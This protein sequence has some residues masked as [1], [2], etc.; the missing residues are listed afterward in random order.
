MH[1]TISAA[2]ARKKLSDLLGAAHHGQARIVITRGGKPYAAIVSLEA[3]EALEAYE[4]AQDLEAAEAA[5][6]EGDF[7]SL[8]AFKRELADPTAEP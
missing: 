6:A 8:D 3:L 4:D 5:M 1:R 2:E 7:I